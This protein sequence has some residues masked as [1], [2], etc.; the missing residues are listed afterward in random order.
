MTNDLSKILKTGSVKQ[1]LKLLNDARAD[2]SMGKDPALTGKEIDELSDSFQS[3]EEIRLY[4]RH[5]RAYRAFREFLASV[6]SLHGLYKE[7]IAYITGF[8]LLWDTYERSEEL[9]NSVIA[10]VKDKKTKELIRKQFANR[11]HFLYADIEADK[12]GFLRFYTDNNSTK[13][14]AKKSAEDYSIEGILKLW[15]EKAEERARHTKTF[16]KVLLDYIEETDYKPEAFRTYLRSILEELETDPA[17]LPKFSKQQATER[18]YSNL[19]L[20]AKY[21]VYPDPENTKIPEED[22]DRLNK[23]LRSMINNE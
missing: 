15:K 20:M 9:L 1:R 8:V 10:Q 19:D 2:M 4:N 6:G 17:L 11:H 5:L 13:K 14:K 12:E 23:S 7:A 16:A 3:A 21:F 22:Y 18:Q